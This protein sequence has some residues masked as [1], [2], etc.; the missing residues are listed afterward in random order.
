MSTL[1]FVEFVTAVELHDLL[2]ALV[3]VV[4]VAVAGDEVLMILGGDEG[5]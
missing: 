3:V 1:H 4:V 2:V 5:E